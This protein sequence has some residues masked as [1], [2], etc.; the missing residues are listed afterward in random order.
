MGPLRLVS[1]IE[2]VIGRKNS[3]SS[4]ENLEYGHRDPSH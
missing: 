1:T 2:E 4:L 3:G